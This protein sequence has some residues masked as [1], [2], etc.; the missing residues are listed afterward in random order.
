[1]GKHSTGQCWRVQMSTSSPTR[2]VNPK[3]D[4]ILLEL[5][6]LWSLLGISEVSSLIASFDQQSIR[7]KILIFPVTWPKKW[8]GKSDIFG[9][10][11]LL[12]Y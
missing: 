9:K 4:V 2:L 7:P 11:F 6:D 12:H 3:A 5:P 1:M 10:F 8:V